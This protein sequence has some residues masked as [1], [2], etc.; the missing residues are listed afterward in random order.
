[1]FLEQHFKT[2]LIYIFF[3]EK[4]LFQPNNTNFVC[5]MAVVGFAYTPSISRSPSNIFFFLE[6]K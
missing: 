3:L 6:K 2:F 4:I 1:M 5:E